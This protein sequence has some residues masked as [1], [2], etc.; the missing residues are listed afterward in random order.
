MTQLRSAQGLSAIGAVPTRK[1]PRASKL[2]NIKLLL[3]E[4]LM[5]SGVRIRGHGT[6][7]RVSQANKS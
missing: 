1:Q 6:H 2:E 3:A 5:G 7:W 4:V